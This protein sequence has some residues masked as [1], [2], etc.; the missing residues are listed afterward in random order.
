MSTF[1]TAI[2][3]LIIYCRDTPVHKVTP[4]TRHTRHTHSCTRHN[5]TQVYK[6]V[7][8][9]LASFRY[10]CE[11]NWQV[12]PFGVLVII[13]L[14]LPRAREMEN[15]APCARSLP[16]CCA[17]RLPFS[18]GRFW[19]RLSGQ[20]TWEADRNRTGY[21]LGSSPPIRGT[22][23]LITAAQSRSRREDLWWDPFFGPWGQHH[24]IRRAFGHL[25]NIHMLLSVSLTFILSLSVALCPTH[26][27]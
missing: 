10:W 13:V 4:Y 23:F 27:F 1:N 22:I 3:C 21:H 14:L 9:I 17:L 16:P 24:I 26:A 20:Y 8:R 15:T 5:F 25:F 19:V 2:P 6:S 11:T 18:D 7:C 12:V